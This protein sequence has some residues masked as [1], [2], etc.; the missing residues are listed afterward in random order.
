[1]Q[2]VNCPVFNL[3]PWKKKKGTTYQRAVM[4]EPFLQY[5]APFRFGWPLGF[6]LEGGWIEGLVVT[7][8]EEKE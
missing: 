8:Y 4:P 3:A 7:L 5:G 6:G 1:M 2:S